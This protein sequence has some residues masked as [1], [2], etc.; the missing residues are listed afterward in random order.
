MPKAAATP[1]IATPTPTQ[2]PVPTLQADALASLIGATGDTP[3][4]AWQHLLALW[5]LPGDAITVDPAGPCAAAASADVHCVSGRNNR[6]E[7]LVA[8]D[9]PLLLRLADGEA[10]AWALLLGA[11][12]RRARVRIG[13]RTVDLDRALLQ[14][15]WDGRY[16]GL[17]RGPATLA[18]PPGVGDAGPA[19]D[20]IRARL[21]TASPSAAGTPYDAALRD[22]VRTL[23]AARGLPADGIAG[24]L[25]LMALASDDAG[26]RLARVLE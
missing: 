4:P 6:L 15:R 7:A 1:A 22:A 17:W 20:W 13:S 21:P 24:P 8:L 19:V 14:A 9:R 11:D 12:A 25:T 18:I 3:V 26:P 16:A 5:S 23:Q 10:S 2:V